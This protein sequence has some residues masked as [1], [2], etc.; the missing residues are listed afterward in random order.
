MVL[1][2]PENVGAKG[3]NATFILQSL[4]SIPYT[5]I[6]FTLLAQR[7]SPPPRHQ[8]LVSRP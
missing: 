6:R 4:V 2:V 7:L 3:A 1:K 5:L 8:Q